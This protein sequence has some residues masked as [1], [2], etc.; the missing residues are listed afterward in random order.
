MCLAP[1]LQPKGG[2]LKLEN[3]KN[4]A[5]AVVEE[6]DSLCGRMVPM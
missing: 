3:L 6:V 1:N 2:K 4:L 5:Y